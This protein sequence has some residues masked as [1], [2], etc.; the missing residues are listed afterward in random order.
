[1]IMLAQ[2]LNERGLGF[3]CGAIIFYG[4]D[5]MATGVYRMAG[6]IVSTPSVEALYKPLAVWAAFSTVIVAASVALLLAYRKVLLGADA[7]RSASHPAAVK[8]V[9]SGVLRPGYIAFIFLG[10]PLTAATLTGHFDVANWLNANWTPYGPTPWMAVAYVVAEAALISLVSV[11]LA[12]MDS[13][14]AGVP[15]R[16]TRHMVRLAV[17]S[18]VA[19]GLLVAVARPAAHYATQ[20]VGQLIPISAYNILVIVT[21]V[22]LVILW[23][24]KRGRTAPL[25]TTPGMLP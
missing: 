20:A 14:L 13:W 2:L 19:M 5:L 11:V 15:A 24:E 4:L 3:G 17:I 25:T 16:R 21:I 23:I 6:Y 18:G 12:V 1:M 22:L 7:S 10:L 8:L 9:T